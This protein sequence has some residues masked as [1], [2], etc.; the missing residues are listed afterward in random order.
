MF[1]NIHSLNWKYAVQVWVIIISR[2]R[3]FQSST[4]LWEVICLS[5]WSNNSR[6][7]NTNIK[8]Y[9][10]HL[11]LK[12]FDYWDFDKY[13]T[14][15]SQSVYLNI[16]LKYLYISRQIILRFDVY[17]KPTWKKL[18]IPNHLSKKWISKNKSNKF[19]Y[20]KPSLNDYYCIFLNI[21]RITVYTKPC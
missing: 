8:R 6:D 2:F 12:K 5:S 18:Y 4:Y 11:F 20:S 19:V 13:Y 10:T 3:E 14:H 15:S 1:L 7:K 17:S 21:L 16:S 9:Q